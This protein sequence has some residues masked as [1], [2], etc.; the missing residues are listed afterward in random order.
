MVFVLPPA[1]QHLILHGL[2]SHYVHQERITTPIDAGA[3]RNLTP[4]SPPNN[5]EM[6]VYHQ[7]FGN[8]KSDVFQLWLN[9]NNIIEFQVYLTQDII[10]NGIPL[11]LHVTPSK[12][13][14]GQIK[15]NDT[16]PQ[17]FQVNYWAVSFDRKQSD[18]VFQ[19]LK[20][21]SAPCLCLSDTPTQPGTGKPIYIGRRQKS[22]RC[23]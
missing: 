15:N 4:V 3:T 21:F 6:I 8:V 14:T 2:G 13:V 7:T 16:E 11:F 20:E 9:H 10:S 19:L 12:Q 18:Q 1:L 5:R 23:R 17:I 22:V